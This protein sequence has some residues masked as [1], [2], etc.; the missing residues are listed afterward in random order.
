MNSNPPPSAHPGLDQ[1]AGFWLPERGSRGRIV[2]LGP[3]LDQ[4]L[5][6]HAYPPAIAH[7]LAEA[8]VL[9][10]LLGSLLKGAGDQ[11]TLQIQTGQIEPGQIEAAQASAGLI[12]LL[13]C[14]Y[15]DGA[16][17]GYAE[18]ARTDDATLPHAGASLPTL[19][20]STASFAI[21][22]E[23]AST[24]RRYQGIV[25]LEGDSLADA[26]ETYFHQS[27]QVPALLRTAISLGEAGY[28][29]GGL[30]M[31]HLPEGEQGRERLHARL[32]HEHWEHVAALAG[33]VSHGELVDRGLAIEDLLWRLFHDAGQ[34]NLGRTTSLNRGCRCSA[35]HYE[36]ILAR[37]S[38]QDRRE[39]AN[40]D[41][42]I[43]VDCA[44]CSREFAIQD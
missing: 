21:T 26:V 43:L 8:L 7:C 31:Q 44:F 34:I 33:T 19:F 23:V 14:D 39:M 27:E 10:A 24:R 42:V 35:A 28:E 41:G 37:F 40:E 25:P 29:A 30:L 36:S 6:A 9:T 11:L 22:F 16:L 20:G 15:R 12:R 4:I 3:V 18:P 2:R 17:R 1:V 32:D 13:V 38:R 5:S